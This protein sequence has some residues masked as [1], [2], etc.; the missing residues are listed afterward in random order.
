MPATTKVQSV[1]FDKQRTT[2]AKARAWLKKN[3]LVTKKIDTTDKYYRFRQFTPTY[4]ARS[5]SSIKYRT[6]NV[7]PGIFF[8]LQIHGR[9]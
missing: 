1:L 8:I 6:I 7:A 5:A 2:P 3:G 4:Q 9:S